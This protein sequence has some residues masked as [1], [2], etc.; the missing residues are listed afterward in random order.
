MRGGISML[1]IEKINL[2][3]EVFNRILTLIA[4]QGYIPG[5]KTPSE[6]ELVKLLGVSRNTVR[7]ALSRLNALGIL[8]VRHG[9]GYF[10]RDINVDVFTNLQL[11]ILLETYADLETLT[12]FRIGIESQGA[13]LAA[14][15]A[16]S[17]DLEKMEIALA[18]AQANIQDEDKFAMY[19]MDF[20]VTVASASNNLMIYRSVAMIK[21]LYT[22]WLGRF[23]RTH[24]KWKSNEFHNLIYKAIK[25]SKPS[26]A[27]RLMSEHMTDVLFKVKLDSAGKKV[28]SGQTK[29]EFDGKA[30]AI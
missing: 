9:E 28:A 18:L 5:N 11:P 6:H 29:E 19:D 4:A 30:A 13:A 12:E 21:T 7:A 24:G 10:L 25:D 17:E 26:E 2:C 20:H 3:D 14:D 23:V 1:P 8:E 16:T 22:V 15:R 27:R